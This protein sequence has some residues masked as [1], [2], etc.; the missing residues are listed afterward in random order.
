MTSILAR[1][2]GTDILEKPIARVEHFSIFNAGFSFTPAGIKLSFIQLLSGTEVFLYIYSIYSNWVQRHAA[3]H[4]EGET[5]SNPDTKRKRYMKGLQKNNVS[6]WIASSPRRLA[7]TVRNGCVKN[8]VYLYI[9]TLQSGTKCIGY[10][11]GFRPELTG[12]APARPQL[13]IVHC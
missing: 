4:C 10:I 11:N 2:S 8:N 7:M 6:F 12:G 3:R 9:K 13:L 1:D 5:R